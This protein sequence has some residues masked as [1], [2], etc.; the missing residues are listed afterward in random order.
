MTVLNGALVKD[1]IAGLLWGGTSDL[2]QTSFFSPNAF[3]STDR[4]NGAVHT[5]NLPVS[6]TPRTLTAIKSKCYFDD[7][8]NRFHLSTKLIDVGN[9]AAVKI[10]NVE[11]WSAYVVTQQLNSISKINADGIVIGEPVGNEAPVI[12][13]AL[14]A[15]T[16]VFNILIAGS[17]KIDA[18]IVFNFASSAPLVAVIGNRV[19]VWPYKPNYPF[20]ESL[21]WKTD[22]IQSYNR[23]QRIA[24]RDAPRQS[25]NFESV[26]SASDFSKA[27]AIA[28]QW[29]HRVF[30][31]PIWTDM[32]F[33]GSLNNGAM[34]IDVDTTKAD[35][36][37]D[38]LVLIWESNSSYVVVS[39][40]T[41]TTSRIN[42]KDPLLS[43]RSKAYVVPVR[44]G[45]SFSGIQF[46]RDADCIIKALTDFDVTNNKNL[47]YDIGLPKYKSLQVLIDDV[48][49]TE[50]IS[51]KYIRSTDI[52]DN[53]SGIIDV[54]TTTNYIN[55]ITKVSIRGFSKSDAWR[56]KQFFSSLYGRQKTFFIPSRTD[57]F[58]IA[59]NIQINDTAIK[60]QSI[61][62]TQ[63]YDNQ[64]FMLK[65]DTG[66]MYYSRIIS[67][68][69]LGGGLEQLNIES[70]FGIYIPI[71]SV[72]QACILKHVRLDSDKIDFTHSVGDHMLCT[73]NVKEIPYGL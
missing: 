65:T 51:D 62:F 18:S 60:I 24:L 57:D 61:G 23:E 26:I 67:S 5:S 4:F 6:T 32:R 9:L 72:V 43:A 52:F 56:Y 8:Y 64:F 58:I 19:V 55:I 48:M 12:Y 47:N 37:S 28:F 53:G 59:D 31:V 49:S 17:P 33:V 21:E 41:I 69:E 40:T 14:E 22:I 35:F 44:F 16:Y 45:F 1:A 39:S 7:Y 66:I 27:K 71:A 25:V 50:A 73:F 3:Y 29:A 54:D 70:A 30:G 13:N 10:V 63:Y 34:Y 46:S 15:M 38:D 36:R 11:I 68:I 42:L 20:K 2:P